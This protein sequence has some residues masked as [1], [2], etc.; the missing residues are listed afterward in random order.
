[1]VFEILKKGAENA[2]TG[3]ELCKILNLPIRELTRIIEKE[4]RSGKPICAATGQHPGY[5]AAANKEELEKYCKRLFKRAG[6]LHKTRRACIKIIE[7]LP[8]EREN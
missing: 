1:M 6:E 4:R 7:D 8:E 2:T 5:Y 3:K